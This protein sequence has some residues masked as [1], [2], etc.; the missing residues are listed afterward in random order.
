MKALDVSGCDG[1]V[2][3]VAHS[4]PPVPAPVLDDMIAVATTRSAPASFIVKRARPGARL[5]A[6][7]S[8]PEAVAVSKLTG[9]RP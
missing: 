7:R 2:N 6:R 3:R 9:S 8:L 4:A 5:K 1:P